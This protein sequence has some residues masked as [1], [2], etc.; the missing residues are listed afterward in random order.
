MLSLEGLG[1]KFISSI[2]YAHFLHI[3]VSKFVELH[4]RYMVLVDLVLYVLATLV[5]LGLKCTC[6]VYIH[7]NI[8]SYYNLLS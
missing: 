1:F 5:F 2:V 7:N 6:S 8:P 3:P 4:N